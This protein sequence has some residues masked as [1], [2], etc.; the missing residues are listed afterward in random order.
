M[1]NEPPKNDLQ[2]LWRSQSAEPVNMS[3]EEIRKK[4]RRYQ[5]KIWRRNAREYLA[6]AA[7]AAVMTFQAVSAGDP[8]RRV[9]AAL[10]VAAML[11]VAYHLHRG[12]SARAVPEDLALTSCL[13]FHRRELERQRDLLRSV[14]RWYLGPMIPGMAVIGLAGLVANP[15]R[16]AHPKLFVAR[17]GVVVAL[18][19]FG[20]GRLNRRHA[21]RLQRQIDALDRLGRE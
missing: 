8:L 19:F 15:S 6:A 16:M 17:Y 7:V 13:E 14:W 20:V 11:Y 2:S 10:C 1:P 12:G 5:R 4:A 3:L 21:G 9:G 18:V